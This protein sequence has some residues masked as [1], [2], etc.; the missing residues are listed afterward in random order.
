MANDLIGQKFGRLL[1]ILRMDNNKWGQ[2]R[3]LCECD[4]NDKNEIM[5]IGGN[6]KNGHTKSCGC[7]RKEATSKN[8][9]NNHYGLKHGYYKTRFYRSWSDMIQRCNNPNNQS[10]HYYGGRGITVC[11]R[12]LK[13]E[14]FLEDMIKDWEPRLTIE[15]KDKNGNYCKNNCKWATRK[16]QVRNRRNNFYVKHREKTQLLIEWSK[17]TGIPYKILWSR[18]VK[19]KWP[20]AKA[21]TTPVRRKKNGN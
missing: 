3:W 14:N 2:L 18:I 5:V 7:L 16:E 15:R 8:Y 19:L 21:L 12:W 17:E 9:Q 1:V 4:C 13:F 10:Y 6:L 11:E 20:I